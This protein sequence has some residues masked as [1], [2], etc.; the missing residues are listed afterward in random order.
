MWQQ[1]R[2]TFWPM[3]AFI[4]LLCAIGY[5]FL[6]MPLVAAVFLFVMLQFGSLFGAW[7]GMRLRRQLEKSNDR[8]PLER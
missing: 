5:F 6:K 3:Q 7:W 4:L 8:L 1:Y 2:K